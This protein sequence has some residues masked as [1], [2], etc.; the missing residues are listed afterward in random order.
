MN[1]NFMIA[2]KKKPNIGNY[3]TFRKNFSWNRMER[4]LEFFDKQHTLLNAAHNA[5]D[6]HATDKIAIIHVDEK[7]KEQRFSFQKLKEESNKFANIL[8]NKGIHKGDRVFIFLPRIPMVPVTFLGVLKTGAIA[9]TL[10]AAFS[11][12][13][14]ED[15]LNNSRAKI[16]VTNKELLKRINRRK[17][18]HL[19][20]IIVVGTEDFRKKMKKAS[21]DFKCVHTKRTDP[22]FMLYTSGST[23]KPKGIVH[24]HN[25]ILQQHATAKYVLDLHP[26]DMYWCTA[27]YGWVTGIAYNILGSLSNYVTHISYAGR[28]DPKK[29]YQI[30]K[31]YLVSVWYT[32]PTAIRMLEGAG[33]SGL[34][35]LPSLRLICSVGEPLNP[36]AIHWAMK[37]FKQPIYDNYWQTETGGMMIANYPGMPIK[38]GSMGK[39]FPGIKAMIVDDKGKPLGAGKE[40]NLAFVPGWPSMTIG[41]WDNKRRYAKYFVT[42]QGK[43]RYLTGDRGFRDKS[44]YFWFVGRSDDVIKT[45]GERVGPFEVESALIEHKDVIEVGVIGKPD[46]LRGQIIKAFIVLRKG[47][48]KSEKKRVEIQKFVKKELAGHAYP[49][50]IEFIDTLPKTKSGKIMRRLLKAKELGL[51]TGDTSTLEK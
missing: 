20:H 25:T 47:V 3:K 27:D 38:P 5:V 26:E 49:R 30:I 8:K 10:F 15:R 39:P 40:G 42:Y 35:K 34:L 16:L 17:L 6:R 11:H 23:G 50:E 51:P 28:F 7:G 32:A 24:S 2:R 19:K 46:A 43:K 41:V 9:G 14:L 45:S 13:A 44:G 12:K 18:P 4:D 21:S 31:K 33:Y 1:N 36:E 22:A 29:W 48:P 37:A